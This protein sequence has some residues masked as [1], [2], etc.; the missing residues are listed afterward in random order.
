[1]KPAHLFFRRAGVFLSACALA[2][3]TLPPPA[4][5]PAEPAIRQAAA[6]FA[7]TGRVSASDGERSATGRF[8]WRRQPAADRWTISGPFGQIAARLDAGPEGAELSL[9]D[10]TRHHAARAA[11][12]MPAF[13][14]GIADAELSLARLAAWVQAAPPVGS[15]VRTLDAHGRPARL[16]DQGWSIDYLGYQDDAAA[17]LPRLLEIFRGDFRLRLVIDQWETEA[18]SAP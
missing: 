10:G 4:A 18:E 12:L 11:D 1:L 7:L 17:A 13:F 15:E 6:A 5:Q 3:C 9:A 14:P 2:A 8:E 16:I